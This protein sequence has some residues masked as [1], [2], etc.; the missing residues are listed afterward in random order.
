MSAALAGGTDVAINLV[1]L[2]LREV[3]DAPVLLAVMS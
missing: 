2:T 3:T 1:A